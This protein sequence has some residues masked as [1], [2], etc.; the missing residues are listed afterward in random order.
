MVCRVFED[1]VFGYSYDGVIVLIQAPRFPERL[2]IKVVGEIQ[3][4][5]TDVA[6]VTKREKG[7]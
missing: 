1:S 2:S 5:E 7:W 3:V 6:I 4:G